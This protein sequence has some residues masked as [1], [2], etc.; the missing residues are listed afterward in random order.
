MRAFAMT[1]TDTAEMM[2]SI[3]SGS[4]MR[5]TPPCERMSLGTRSR[6]MTA[7]APASS[8]IRAWSAVTTSMI[9]PP[10]S[11][12]ASPTFVAQVLRSMVVIRPDILLSREFAAQPSDLSA[13]EHAHLAPPGHEVVEVAAAASGGGKDRL[14]PVRP[15]QQRLGR[16]VA[17]QLPGVRAEFP[18]LPRAALLAAVAVCQPENANLARECR[19][20]VVRASP[21][22]EVDPRDAGDTRHAGND[23][24]RTVMGCVVAIRNELGVRPVACGRHPLGQPF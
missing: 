20:N 1:G 17:Q 23:R 3:R 10:A 11:M 9:T 7:T 24:E 21:L 4:L 15:L 16:R 18:F 22:P 12:R 19:V 14:I 6:A 5:A 2:P 8:A 13:Q